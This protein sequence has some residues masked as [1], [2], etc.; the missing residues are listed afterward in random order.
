[1][2]WLTPKTDWKIDDSINFS[3]FNRIENNTIEVRNYLNSIQYNIPSLTTIT[4]RTNSSIDFLSSINRLETN[5]ETIKNNFATPLD[6]KPKVTW[7]LGLG[8]SFN[9]ANRLENNL[10]LLF[11]L[12]QLA[13]Q[14]YKYCGTVT[15][16]E[17]GVIY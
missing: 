2:A 12:G 6:W 13:F 1:M 14:N 4:N 5:I 3:D 15:C 17:E 11:E 7:T 16:G 9:D 10:K 8:F